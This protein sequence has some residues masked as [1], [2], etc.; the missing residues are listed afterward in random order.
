MSRWLRQ[1]TQTLGDLDKL[2][3]GKYVFLFNSANQIERDIVEG[4]RLADGIKIRP[5]EK[6]R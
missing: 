3:G 4:W 6:Q 5:I 2:R 1:N